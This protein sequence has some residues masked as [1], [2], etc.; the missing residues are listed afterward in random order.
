MQVLLVFPVHRGFFLFFAESGL[1]VANAFFSQSR[2]LVS[3]L[4]QSLD[5]LLL[6][7]LLDVVLDIRL[8]AKDFGLLEALDRLLHDHSLN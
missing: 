1:V 3:D 7:L 6:F 4:P 8:A 2:L 5:P